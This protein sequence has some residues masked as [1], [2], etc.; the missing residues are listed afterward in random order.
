MLGEGG[1]MI[2][3]VCDT[4][5]RVQQKKSFVKFKKG[6]LRKTKGVRKVAGTEARKGKL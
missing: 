1:K 6:V 4:G 5:S 2:D 3:S